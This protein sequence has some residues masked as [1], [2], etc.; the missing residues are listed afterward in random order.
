MKSQEKQE[1]I[2]GFTH[3]DTESR[4]DGEGFLRGIERWVHSGT[5]QMRYFDLTKPRYRETDP[6]TGALG[7]WGRLKSPTDDA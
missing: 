4:E 7:P 1:L 5:L 2:F 6:E 3:M